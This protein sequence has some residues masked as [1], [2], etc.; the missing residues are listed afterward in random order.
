MEVPSPL[1]VHCC[2]HILV[3]R[4]WGNLTVCRCYLCPIVHCVI[5]VNTLDAGGGG[6]RGTG[7]YVFT[8][9]EEGGTDTWREGGPEGG[10]AMVW[11][12][13]S[14]EREAGREGRS[15]RGQW[16]GPTV[17]YVWLI[18]EAELHPSLPQRSRNMAR[19]IFSRIG[20]HCK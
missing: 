5:Q 9:V 16:C 10:R 17:V 20:A 14:G 6:E 8:N 2:P 18:I 3:R 12:I 1:S 4:P 7:V 11:T 19:Q 13:C 15:Q